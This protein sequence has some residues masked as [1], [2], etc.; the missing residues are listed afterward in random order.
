MAHCPPEVEGQ[1]R[2]DTVAT[3]RNSPVGRVPLRWDMQFPSL[4]SL[5][6]CDQQ[7]V[8]CRCWSSAVCM[9]FDRQVLIVG[10]CN[11]PV[12]IQLS[13]ASKRQLNL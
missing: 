11:R 2:R 8:Q 10:V 7:L 1:A 5:M 6:A 13:K 12:A 4:P 3:Q 9:L